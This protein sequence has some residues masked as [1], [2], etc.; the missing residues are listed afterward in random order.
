[1]MDLDNPPAFNFSSGLNF[2]P[3]KEEMLE[4][5]KNFKMPNLSRKETIGGLSKV[6]E[7][8]EEKEEDALSGRKD[9]GLRCS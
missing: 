9:W 8:E 7:V 2:S 1:M 3:D 6:G 5:E 4:E